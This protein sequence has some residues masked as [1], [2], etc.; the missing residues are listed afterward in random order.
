MNGKKFKIRLFFV[1]LMLLSSVQ[2]FASDAFLFDDFNELEPN[3]NQSHWIFF[4]NAEAIKLRPIPIFT[5]QHKELAARDS[6][7]IGGGPSL[8]Y[9]WLLGGNITTS[10]EL[11]L[12]LI[13]NEDGETKHPTDESIKDYV[14]SEYTERDQLYGGRISQSL[15]YAIETSWLVFEPFV[16]AYAGYGKTYSKVT[17]FWDT[18]TDSE[19]E[20]Y[21]SRINETMYSV[22]L[23]AGMHFIARN[24]FQS[25]LKII[26]NTFSYIQRETEVSTQSGA[27][28]PTRS[29][30]KESIHENVDEYSLSLGFGYIF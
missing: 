9:K 27:N 20:N 19:Y 24:G 3:V 12:Y 1:G 28:A 14:V 10:S 5:L 2:I 26:K 18:Q 25:Y 23:A 22:G 6:I 8:A 15:G 21:D 13:Q 11:M 16:Q 4:L 7:F 17:Y 29:Y 30:K